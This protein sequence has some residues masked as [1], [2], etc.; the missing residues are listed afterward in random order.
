M[1]DNIRNLAV[2]FTT[3]S[4]LLLLMLQQLTVIFVIS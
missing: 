1:E 2:S 3:M 4:K